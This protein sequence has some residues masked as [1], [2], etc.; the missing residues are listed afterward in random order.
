[1]RWQPFAV[2]A[3]LLAPPVLLAAAVWPEGGIGGGGGDI[4]AELGEGDSETA[5]TDG[6][7]STDF[8]VVGP[9]QLRIDVAGGDFDTTLTLV[10]PDSGEQIAFNDDVQG[11]DPSLVV[12]LDEGASVRAQVRSFDGSAGRFVISVRAAD[13]APA[14]GDDAGAGVRVPVE[15]PPLA[16]GQTET[17]IVAG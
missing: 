5:T 13:D 4:E 15:P 9:G 3:A 8:L 12:E 11:W 10:D 1:V 7:S 14:P 2:T 17:T 6:L 16:P